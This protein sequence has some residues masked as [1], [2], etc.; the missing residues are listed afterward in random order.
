MADALADGQI[1]GFCAGEPWGSVAVARGVGVILTTNASIWRSSPEKVLG[2]RAAW[3]EDDPRP[4][5]RAGPRRLIAPASGA[6]SPANRAE[7][8][9]LLARHRCDWRCRPR[10]SSAAWNGGS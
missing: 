1:D 6:T 9:E 2:V 5:R 10:S 4:A 8:A 3:A 7:L